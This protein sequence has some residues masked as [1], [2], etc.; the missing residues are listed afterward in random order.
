[1]RPRSEAEVS[2]AIRAAAGPLA[3]VGGGTRR[4]GEVSGAVVETGGL[5]GVRLYEPGAL[6]LVAGAGTPLAEVEALLAG[7][8]QRLA[9]EPPDL[10]G[11]L[12]RSGSST[13]G[14]V[15]A[16]NASGPRRVQVGAC[17]D[18]M[19]GLRFVDGRGDVV[20]NG[21]RVM[22]N[23]TGYDLVKLLAGSRG[24]LG[25]IT[26]V[27]LKVQAVPEA[28]ATLI[29]EAGEV[30]GLA[31]LH[32]ALKTPFDLSGAAWAGGRVFL[33]V[34]G[35]AGSVAYRAGALRTALAGDWRLADGTEST[36]IWR[37]V[38]NVAAFAGKPGAVWRLVV[39][40]TAAAGIVAQLGA[41]QAI[42]DWGGGLVWLLTEADADVR[43][44]VGGHG[45]ATLVRS[46][47]GMAQPL[48]P[49]EAPAVATL[50][51]RLRASF[52]PRGLFAGGTA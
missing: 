25:V 49:P 28:E 5:A 17:R 35:L 20:K 24:A 36:K 43:G 8:R 12:G 34:E 3:I 48:L 19:L 29:C 38:R 16:A 41:A 2:E 18:A 15:A 40:P 32:A 23:V 11:L 46:L 42:Y 33:R 14:G 22:K 37:D 45:H 21:G 10:R 30:A 44:A 13:L 7:E 52:D 4:L 50:T 9:F 1:M 31:L 39:K 26:E 6:T 47:P 27:S 51:A